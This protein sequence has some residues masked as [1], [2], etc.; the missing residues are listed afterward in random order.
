MARRVYPTIAEAIEIHRQLIEEFGGSHGLRDRGGLESAIFRPQMGY[1]NGLAEEAAAL[2]EP[3]ANNHAFV[4]GN[5][6]VSFAVTDTF[7]RLNS[8]YLEVEPLPA[9]DFITESIGKGE[10]RFGLILAWISSHLK[11]LESGA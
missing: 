8:F 9:H 2:M 1:Y 4:D 3:L 6:R 10:F 7:L 5:K 11:P